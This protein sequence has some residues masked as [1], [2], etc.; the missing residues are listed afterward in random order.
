MIAAALF[1]HGQVS[2][3]RT[4]CYAWGILAGSAVGLLRE[5][6][7]A[8]CT[9]RRTTRCTTRARR[10]ASPCIRVV[11]TSALGYLCA[12][13]LPRLLGIDRALGCGRP[14]GLGRHCGLGRVLAPS[15][16]AEP[17][18]RRHRASGRACREAVGVGARRGRARVAVRAERR[19]C[20]ATRR[21]LGRGRARRLRR[22]VSRRRRRCSRV[23]EA[24]GAL[25]RMRRRVRQ[26][27]RARRGRP[28]QSFG[29]LFRHGRS[30]LR[31]RKNPASAGVARSVS[32]A[33]RGR[34][35]AV[36]R[37]GQAP[38]LARAQLRR[39]ATTPR[40]SRRAR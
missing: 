17:A 15:R 16:A 21:L 31:S 9:R 12:L 13:P 28:A 36:R 23:P 18:H 39:G 25:A 40:A 32:L 33:R 8:A 5:H 37:Q 30:R 26:R 22:G 4:R 1:Q 27:A 29:V 7:W 2:R 11:L 6:A 19:R 34:D 35:G 20:T 3:T 38:S 14:H 24:R 10:C